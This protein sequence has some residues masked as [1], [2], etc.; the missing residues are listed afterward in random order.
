MQLMVDIALRPQKVLAEWQ[1]YLEWL[2][3]GDGIGPQESV[4]GSIAKGLAFGSLIDSIFQLLDMADPETSFERF[5]TY[6]A[7]I[8]SFINIGM[9]FSGFVEY[10]LSF[11]DILSEGIKKGFDWIGR[12][13]SGL[14]AALTVAV[15]EGSNNWAIAQG[16][17]AGDPI[18][19][20][21]GI[22]Y[23]AVGFLFGFLGVS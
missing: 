2:E 14:K 16:W 3:S 23:A 22:V 11:I 12:T 5:S 1:A 15:A 6:L 4:A 18:S 20:G 8:A 13:T 10:S 17:I 21:T 9:D 19:A 7:N